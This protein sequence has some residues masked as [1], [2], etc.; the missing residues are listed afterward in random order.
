[1]S[2]PIYPDTT[3]FLGQV[4]TAVIDRPL[5]SHHP[6]WGFVLPVNYGY[7]PGVPA[8][9]GDDLDAYVLNVAVPLKKFTGLCVALIHRRDD[10]DDKLI[11]VPPGQ[12]ISDAQIREQTFF[13]ERFF[14]SIIIR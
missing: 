10:A 5:N 11:L 1:M 9:D 14:H 2:E 8:P 3:T 4:V 12:K 7:L 6:Q 13:Q